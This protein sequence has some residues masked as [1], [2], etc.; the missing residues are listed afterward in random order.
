MVGAARGRAAGSGQIGDANVVA[1]HM[2]WSKTVDPSAVQGIPGVVSENSR[3]FFVVPQPLGV[4]RRLSPGATGTEGL[5]SPRQTEVLCFA[6]A[7]CTERETALR[8][9]IATATVR[10]HLARARERLEVRS[11]CQ[12]VAVAVAL[13]MIEVSCVS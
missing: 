6:A 11:T 13:G 9:G 12:A 1:G 2:K 4:A 3:P 8:L 7:G 5:L 10:G